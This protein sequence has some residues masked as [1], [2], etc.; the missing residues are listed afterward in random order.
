MVLGLIVA[1][2]M[3]GATVA[4]WAAAFLEVGLLG[5][6]GIFLGTAPLTVLGLGLLS[7]QRAQAFVSHP[8]HCT[9]A[10]ARFPHSP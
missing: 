10:V 7:A 4:V 1:G 3:G 8:K 2:W 6:V 9:P 5:S